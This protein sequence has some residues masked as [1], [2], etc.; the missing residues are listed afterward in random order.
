MLLK[1]KGFTLYI[2]PAVLI[3]VIGVVGGLVGRACR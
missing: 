3:A 2:A 1:L